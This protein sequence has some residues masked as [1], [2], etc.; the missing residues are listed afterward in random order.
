MY[1]SSVTYILKRKDVLKYQRSIEDN[2]GKKDITI[3][4]L[5]NAV[6]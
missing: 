5:F 3:F 2:K 6:L 4:I 1:K